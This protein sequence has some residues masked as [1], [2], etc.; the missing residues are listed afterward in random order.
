MIRFERTLTN[1]V[2]FEDASKSRLTKFS[3][4]K[5]N[6]GDPLTDDRR[7]EYAWQ[8]QFLERY[9]NATRKLLDDA[10][11]HQHSLTLIRQQRFNC[12]RDD[13]TFIHRLIDDPSITCKPADKNLGLALVSSAWYDTE[14]R[15]ML[16]DT[17]TYQRV[18]NTR[19]ADGKRFSS[20]SLA[21]RLLDEVASIVKRHASTLEIW[22]ESQYDQILKYMTKRIAKSSASIPVIYLL[23]KV[24]KP[25]GLCGR[26]IVPCTRWVTTPA[27][28]LADHLL[29][30][31]VRAANIPW[32]VKDTKSFVNELEHLYV[33]TRTTNGRFD[34]GIFVTADIA[35]LYTNIDTRMGLELV[36]TF[37]HEQKVHPDHLRLIMDLLSFVMH[38]SYLSFKDS[39]YRQID[40]TAM[41]TA[42]APTYANIVVYMLERP[43]LTEFTRSLHL[44][45]RFLDDVFAYIDGVDVDVFTRRLNSMHPKLIFE[46]VTHPTEAAF[47][48]LSIYKGPR[49]HARGV[50]DTRVHQKKLNLY[51]YIP[52]LSYHTDAAKRSFI[53]TELMRY[54][55]NSSHQ[56]DYIALKNIFFDRLRDRG[57][58]RSFLQ[59]IFTSIFYADRNYFLYPSSELLSHPEIHRQPPQSACLLKRMERVRQQLIDRQD[60]RPAPVFV[61]PF[62]PL[63]RVVP[64]R[65]LLMRHWSQAQLATGLPPPIIAYKSY[66]SL[67]TKL[68]YQKAKRMEEERKKL[69]KSIVASQSRLQ[70][71]AAASTQ[72]THS[73]ESIARHEAPM[74]MSL[75]SQ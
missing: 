67:M 10:I 42:A 73:I 40:G 70:F 43:I 11:N 3:L 36:E 52:F 41:G 64:T 71:T 21:H 46:F 44:Y 26:P 27:S 34:S 16:A 63:S 72:S 20:S 7:L 4:P 74:P 59:P 65:S 68:V 5:R 60:S 57:Y 38:N 39:I 2:L 50:F 49:F 18:D 22:N 56:E 32:I 37:L 8:L 58:P 29:Q 12:D 51:L 17:V 9:G 28:V 45:R 69:F 53:L 48:D 1:A 24:H 47:L 31:I 30:E 33:P 23:I 6:R 75:S 15:R 13:I 62:T 66:P 35:S 14:L 25:K 61:I 19:S 55:R 54:I